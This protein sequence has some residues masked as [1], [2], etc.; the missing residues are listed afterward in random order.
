MK[1]MLPDDGVLHALYL[2]RQ[3]S[4]I[5]S[6]PYPASADEVLY[7]LF[8]SFSLQAKSLSVAYIGPLDLFSRHSEPDGVPIT[9][10]I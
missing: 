2:D 4:P 9:S 8:T 6:Y 10:L 7:D 3:V 1:E 5:I